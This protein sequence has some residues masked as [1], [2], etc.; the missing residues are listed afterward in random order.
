MT[1]KTGSTSG[2]A[3]AA[4]GMQVV[5]G[6]PGGAGPPWDVPFNRLRA[7]HFTDAGGPVIDRVNVWL[8]FWGTA[9]T[10]TPPPT[11]SWN[12][13]AA[14]VELIL[15]SPY[16]SRL[17]QYRGS[18]GYE[19]RFDEGVLGGAFAA[20][21]PTGSG[22]SQSPADPPANFT[23]DD[24]NTSSDIVGTLVANLITSPSPRLPDPDSDPNLLYI[25]IAPS[26]PSLGGSSNGAHFYRAIPPF[27]SNAHIAWLK[28]GTNADV[29]TA[30]LSHELVEAI[31]DPEGDAIVG[32]AGTCSNPNS[33]CEIGDVCENQFVTLPNG[34]T[35]QAYW[36]DA[37]S[38]CIVPTAWPWWYRPPFSQRI[39]DVIALFL[40]IYGGDPSPFG[41]RSEAVRDAAT[42]RLLAS[43][44]GSLPAEDSEEIRA[45]LGPI[46]DRVAR[47][48][49]SEL[50]ST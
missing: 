2:V 28:W 49:G 8:V 45:A 48:L 18:L 22:P 43:L 36:S 9:W 41:G 40:A 24:V 19:S 16:L 4:S 7:R 20:D 39:T 10:R 5:E 47:E 35:V 1:P 3:N 17:R 46:A 50:R 25:V 42:L 21:T 26:D 44:A 29:L 6:G 38:A 13:L 23:N 14:D 33:W 30:V 11:P 27:Q 12:D 34:V 37:D 31:T 32:V 15:H